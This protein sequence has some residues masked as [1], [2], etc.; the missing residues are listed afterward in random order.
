MLPPRIVSINRMCF[1]LCYE[2]LNNV[3][4]RNKLLLTYLDSY[5]ETGSNYVVRL[6]WNSLY[7]SRSFEAHDNLP[8]SASQGLGLHGDAGMTHH[9]SVR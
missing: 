9:G 6:A 7:S 5:L 1:T 4:V 8:A 3:G 2:L